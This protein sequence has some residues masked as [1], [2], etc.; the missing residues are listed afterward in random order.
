MFEALAAAGG[1]PTQVLLASA[2]L[3]QGSGDQ[4]PCVDRRQMPARRLHV[5][6]GQVADRAAGAELLARIPACE[7][8]R[9]DK[10][11]DSKAVRRQIE[12]RGAMP[13]IPPKANRKWKNSF[14]S[15]AATGTSSR[16]YSAN[17][18]TSGASPRLRQERRRA[19]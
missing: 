16:A 2:V 10:G 11:Y 19:P 8:L 14:S 15:S 5:D 4:N 7:I 9:G 18:R 17:R 1:P 3:T 6:G 12:N 13:S